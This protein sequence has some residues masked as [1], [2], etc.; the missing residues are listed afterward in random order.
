MSTPDRLIRSADSV[1]AT[2][3]PIKIIDNMP[4]DEFVK[5]FPEGTPPHI[6]E[7][8][9]VDMWNSLTELGCKYLCSPH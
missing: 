7:D 5:T 2:G 3:T 4:Y 8:L 6:I 9:G 1:L